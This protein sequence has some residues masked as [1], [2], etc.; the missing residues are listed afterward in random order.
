MHK[1]LS[2][3][4]TRNQLKSRLEN[5]VSNR[6]E[7][8]EEN[9][10]NIVRKRSNIIFIALKNIFKTKMSESFNKLKKNCIAVE[11]K[12]KIFTKVFARKLSSW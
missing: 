1:P 10:V 9:F 6:V 7:N 12:E 11:K 5:P 2:R 8:N 3:S 4:S